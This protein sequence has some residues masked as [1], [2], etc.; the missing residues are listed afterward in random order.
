MTTRI[1]RFTH[2]GRGLI[3]HHPDQDTDEDEGTVEGWPEVAY[4]AIRSI[5]H[6]TGHGYPIPA[7]VAYAVLGEL[8]GVGHLL[9]QALGQ[10]GAGLQQSL[11]E[12]DVYDDTPGCSP[13]GA[14]EDAR[15]LLSEASGHAR[16]LGELLEAAQTKLSRQGYRT[17]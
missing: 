11:V 9:P 1:E 16:A 13:E 2:H 15:A 4:E 14:V 10:L 5:N 7:P 8:K 6:L 12:L 3:A 17:Q